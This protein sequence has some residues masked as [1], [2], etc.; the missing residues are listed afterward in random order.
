MTGHSYR[1]NSNSVVVIVPRKMEM[2]RVLL[3]VFCIAISSL[4]YASVL[5]CIKEK[6]RRRYAH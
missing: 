4:P 5:D 1:N 2:F 3:S 6:K